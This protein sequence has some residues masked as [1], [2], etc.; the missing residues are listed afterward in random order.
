MTSDT[1]IPAVTGDWRHA[2]GGA[3]CMTEGFFPIDDA[4]VAFPAGLPMPPARTINM[5]RLG[6]A[7]TVSVSGGALG[8]G[9]AM[10][11]GALV[12]ARV[13]RQGQQLFLFSSRLLLFALLFATILGALAATYATLRIVR[14]S[15]AEA[16]RRGA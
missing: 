16:I 4:A 1:A 5:S 10:A 6:E 3:L 11:V 13:L 9:L 12:D 15:P 14:L 8:I 2:G 7:L